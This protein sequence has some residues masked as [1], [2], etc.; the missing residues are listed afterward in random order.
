MTLYRYKFSKSA[1]QIYARDEDSIVRVIGI[2][3]EDLIIKGGRLNSSF[4]CDWSYEIPSSGFEV[5]KFGQAILLYRSAPQFRL[6]HTQTDLEQQIKM[7]RITEDAILL[8][9]LDDL[10]GLN[11]QVKIL[12]QSGLN[13]FRVGNLYRFD[14][15]GRGD[16]YLLPKDIMEGILMLNDDLPSYYTKEISELPGPII[17]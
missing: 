3:K 13:G 15:P 10:F 16:F 11:N 17:H 8:T 9:S 6:S 14:I 12:N 2:N 1:S 4:S 5:E 7:I